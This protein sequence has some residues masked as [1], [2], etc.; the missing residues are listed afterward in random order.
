MLVSYIAFKRKVSSSLVHG[1]CSIRK[2]RALVDQ[3][4]KHLLWILQSKNSLRAGV[5]SIST[6]YLFHCTSYGFS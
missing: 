1:I 3:L 2:Y 6:V 4:R 5:D